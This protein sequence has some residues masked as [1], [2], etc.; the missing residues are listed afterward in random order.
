[1]SVLV[2]RR[3]LTQGGASA[4]VIGALDSITGR[5]LAVSSDELRVMVNGGDV[6]KA[7]IEAYTKPFQAATGIK[8][9]ALTD[10]LTL[11]KLEL[12][13]TTNSVS[14]DVFPMS[15]GSALVAA[16][17]GLLEP[18]DYSIYKKEE[19]DGLFDFAK[20]PFGVGM[21]IFSYLMVYNTEKF[22][23]NQPRPTNWA[24]FWDVK[25]FPGVRA[26]VSGRNGGEGPWEEALLADGVAP[27]K[28]YP[29]DIDHIFASLDKIKPHIRKWW[30]VGSEIQQI[31][32]DKAADLV[33]S[34][35]GRA[36]LAVSRG[37][38]M[39]L[40]RNQSKL[41]WDYWVIPKGSPNA[42]KAQ[43]FIEFATRAERQAAL[44]QL[45]PEGPANR[46]AFKL[47][48]EKVARKLPTH[49]EY[50]ASAVPINMGWYSE[51]GADGLTNTE[52]LRER[53]N[54]WILR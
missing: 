49:P 45:F 4:L 40:N 13:V 30:T 42:Q 31:M 26:L 11:A 51:R 15:Q 3:R 36:G 41:Q 23:A 5:A 48:E 22:P 28:I 33:Q 35:S 14:V 39:E 44:S 1:M 2:D 34:Y 8:V 16:E 52:R 6:G 32:Q 12:M 27:D 53:W 29:M 38:P 10:Q 7:N 20:Q 47:L 19:L 9:S 54:E 25:K 18:I 50:L 46:N 24:D 17:K 21:V 43:K 37:A